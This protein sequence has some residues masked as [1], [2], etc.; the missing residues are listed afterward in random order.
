MLGNSAPG[1]LAPSF[2]LDKYC[3]H[4]YKLPYTLV[5]NDNTNTTNKILK[6]KGSNSI[7]GT[8]AFMP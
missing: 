1:Y 7:Y 5:N 2:V 4:M 6:N 8:S 3:T